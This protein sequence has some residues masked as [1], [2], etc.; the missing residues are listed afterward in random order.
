MGFKP[1]NKGGLG[2]RNFMV[3]NNVAIGKYTWQIAQ[4][5]DSL[6]I[7]WIHSIYIR[8]ANWW[9]YKPS[10]NVSLAWKLICRVRD[11]FK[12]AYHNNK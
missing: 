12:D 5:A 3:W 6:W 8:D 4:K 2:V 11:M 9:E 10:G 7:K 1:K